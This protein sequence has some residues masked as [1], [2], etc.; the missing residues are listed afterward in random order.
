MT[1][2]NL[3]YAFL[4]LFAGYGAVAQSY[5]VSPNKR[6]LMREGKPFFWLG[7]T[8]W[9][10]F[11]RLDREDATYYLEK[12]AAQG[13][14]VIQAVALAE[15]DGLNVPNTYGDRPL[16][17][18]D[19]TKPNEAY[20]KHVDF[21]IDK[22]AELNL[23]IAFL[24][25]WGDKVFKSTWGKG[26]EVFNKSNAEVYGKW[27][28]NRYKN[29][30]NIIWVLG[31]D[32]TP[33]KDVD[34]VGVWRAMAA[35]VVAGVGGN[36]NAM[37]TFHPQPNKEGSGEWFHD[38][39]WLDFNMF[40]NGH[41]RD[42]AVYEN[43]KRAYDRQPVKPVLDGEPIYE[44]HPVCFNAS[45]LGT[46]NAY[47]VRKAAYLDLFSGAFGHTYGCHD[48]WQMYAP[49]REAVN[50]P[51]IFWQ[52]ALDLPGAKE[53]KFVRKLMESRP[54][55]ERVPDQ[56]VIIEND[57]ASYERIQATRGADYIFVYTS[58]GRSF[59]V[60]PGKISGSQLNAFWYDPKNG[61]TKEIGK[62]DSKA[63][64]QFTPPTSGYGHDWILVLDD[65]SKN[66][67]MP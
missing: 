20:F 67:K 47:D 46:S 51:H 35:G 43:I 21:I 9:E 48:I 32:R 45:E 17:D 24:P 37:M 29:R 39:N 11:H 41:C 16:I 10:L 5:T 7:D 44:D 33:R 64:K 12:R 62:M 22:A 26:P 15:F 38:D 49:N 58:T 1:C 25:T 61:K 55:T 18:N 19:P 28:G 56:T 6:Y 63:V 57:L 50:G 54:I 30:K 2:R 4:L 31:G 3:C 66:Y 8:A 65:A 60:N 23:T 59:S 40:Q 13:F 27:L 14:T 34:D 52:Q 42:A 36:D 53:M